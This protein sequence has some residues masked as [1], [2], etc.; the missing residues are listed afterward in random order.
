M[1]TTLI[2]EEIVLM[3]LEAFASKLFKYTFI[4]LKRKQQHS[5]NVFTMLFVLKGSKKHFLALK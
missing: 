1:I 3:H 2:L 5:L 4:T